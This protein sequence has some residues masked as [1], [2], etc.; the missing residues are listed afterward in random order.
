LEQLHSR[1][2][3]LSRFADPPHSIAEEVSMS[4]FKRGLDALVHPTIRLKATT[5]FPLTGATLGLAY[6]VGFVLFLVG[7]FAPLLVFFAGMWLIA[8]Y[9]SACGCST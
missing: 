3:A 9:P 4:W 6:V 8:N 2:W 7:S 5:E 1:G